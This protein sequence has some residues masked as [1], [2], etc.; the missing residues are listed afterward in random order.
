MVLTLRSHTSFISVLRS[1]LLPFKAQ[2]IICNKL[3]GYYSLQIAIVV[4]LSAP[5]VFV[6]V[7]PMVC[8]SRSSPRLLVVEYSAGRLVCAFD[9]L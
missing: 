5:K 4:A 3:R 9:D 1:T 6:Y 2:L 7:E 8:P